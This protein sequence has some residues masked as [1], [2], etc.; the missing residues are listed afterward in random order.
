M[1]KRKREREKRVR[2]AS[3]GK[4][5]EEARA[6]GREGREKREERD[7]HS[8]NLR[9]SVGGIEKVGSQ[10]GFFKEYEKEQF[11]RNTT[12]IPDATSKEQVDS[13]TDPTLPKPF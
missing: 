11:E 7:A 5:E 8:S 13:A 12:N 9:L 6:K 1:R 4:R 10:R 2:S 3:V